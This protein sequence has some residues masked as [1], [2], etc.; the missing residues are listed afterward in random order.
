MGE[1]DLVHRWGDPP[2]SLAWVVGGHAGVVLARSRVL[3]QGFL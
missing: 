3:S 2:D 1:V